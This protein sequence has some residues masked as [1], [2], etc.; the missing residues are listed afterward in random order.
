LFRPFGLDP[1]RAG[2]HPSGQ[3]RQPAH[4]RRRKAITAMTTA[5][6]RGSQRTRDATKLKLSTR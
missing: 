5:A 1:T 6:G 3:H 2:L 4:Q